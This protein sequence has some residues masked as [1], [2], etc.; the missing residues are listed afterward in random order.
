MN[1]K[2]A[3]TCIVGKSR[4]Y[5]SIECNRNIYDVIIEGDSVLFWLNGEPAE[6]NKIH[7][8][9]INNFKLKI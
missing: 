6:K 9:I 7:S 2:G 4:I 5:Y 1:C 8:M 3:Y